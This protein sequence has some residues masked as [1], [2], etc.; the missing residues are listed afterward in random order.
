[1]KPLRRKWLLL[2]AVGVLFFPH[3]VLAEYLPTLAIRE[4]TISSENIVI[5]K[6][7]GILHPETA[8][9]AKPKTSAEFRILEV[10]KGSSFK[11][12]DTI[13]VKRADMYHLGKLRW[14]TRENEKPPIHTVEKGVLFLE[15]YVGSKKEKILRF[16]CS[17]IRYLTKEKKVL[18]PFQYI[19]P[20]D[21]YLV[22]VA[23]LDWDG[24]IKKVRADIT[25]VGKVFALK[26]I[27]DP[28]E[29]NE[30][31]FKWIET[32]RKEFGGSYFLSLNRKKEETGWGSLEWKVFQWIMESCIQEDCWQ[33]VKL[34]VEIKPTRRH[35]PDSNAPSFSFPEGRKLLLK[36]AVDKSEPK[37]DRWRALS[38][39]SSSFWSRPYENYPKSRMLDKK[40]QIDI[41]DKLIPLLKV[42]DAELRWEVVRTIRRASSRSYA[43][44]NHALPA[45]LEAYK[46]EPPGEARDELAYT[47][48]RLG[49][50]GLWEK[51]TNNPHGILVTLYS[52][53]QHDNNISF[54]LNRQHGY[55]TVYECPV[56]ILERLDD[57][58]KVAETRQMPLPATYLP[59]PWEAGWPHSMGS[60]NVKFSVA[61]F[62]PG[63]WRVT[64]KG[65]AGKDENKARWTSEPKIF[66]VPEPA[67]KPKEIKKK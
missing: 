62:T 41:L 19:N 44:T 47:I 6:P 67:S 43:Y 14:H 42:E 9:G 2:A 46:V 1:M 8:P 45:L 13:R 40:E 16:V 36:V 4:L 50:N 30:A 29:R 37:W 54:N 66:N 63:K 25:A 20:G 21:Y 31:I 55:G 11:A 32:H 52:F 12:G 28:V 24:L 5:A 10:L 15:T 22:P 7:V 33:A 53:A 18:V 39:L 65:T 51:L 59:N 27:K 38:F 64:V 3:A 56:M 17:G 48:I 57:S 35:G 61:G 34:Y 23:G 49:G 26:E 58:G 60:I